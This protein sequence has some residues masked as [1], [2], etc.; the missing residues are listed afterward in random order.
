MD[1]RRRRRSAS[2]CDYTPAVTARKRSG[3]QHLSMNKHTPHSALSV[4]KTHPMP[5]VLHTH[6]HTYTPLCACVCVLVCAVC[7]GGRNR[8]SLSTL[9]SHINDVFTAAAFERGEWARG[10]FDHYTYRLN[11]SHYMA[12]LQAHE[13][14]HTNT[15]TD[16]QTPTVSPGKHTHTHAILRAVRMRTP[17]K[18]MD[19][20]Q[21]LRTTTFRTIAF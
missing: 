18:Y 1:W 17:Y 4:P 6:T 14:T 12:S 10:S 9:T 5:V 19:G 3:H 8:A 7:W 20:C 11:C 21:P 16:R 15:N 2:N 13:H